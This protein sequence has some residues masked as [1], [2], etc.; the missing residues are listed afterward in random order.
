MSGPAVVGLGGGHGLAVTLSAVR[1]YAGQ[2]TAVVSVADDGGSS[3]RIRKDFGLPAPGDIRRCLVA[4][5]DDPESAWARAFGH[6]FSGGDIKGHALGNL[7]LAALVETTGSFLGAIEEAGRLLGAR[8]RVYPAT[9]HAVVLTAETGTGRLSG[10]TA[11]EDHLGA[12]TAIGVEP[13]DSRCPKQA[14]AALK[15]ADQIILGPG[16]LFTSVLAVTAVEEI[17]TLLASKRPVYVCNLKPSKETIGFSAMD[18]VTALRRHGINPAIVVLDPDAI[19]V[20]SVKEHDVVHR[21]RLAG[22]DGWSHDVELL[23]DALGELV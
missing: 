20:G 12:I 13:A 16:S 9:E 2:I 10:Q 8:G 23:A 5:A 1:R 15:Q 7:V 4:L 18:H 6:R 17:R 3:G 22:P 14:I 21:R 11:V 19:E